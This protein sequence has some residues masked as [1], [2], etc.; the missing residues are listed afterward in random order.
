MSGV[1][2]MNYMYSNNAN[3]GQITLT[4]NFDVKTDPNTDQI[5]AQMRQGQAAS[6]LPSEVNSY[7]VTVQKSTAAPL[8]LFDL[9]SPNGT[10]DSEFL[11]N[12][13]YIN[14]N[15]QLT[16]VPGIASVSVFSAGQYAMRFWVKPDQLAKLQITVPEIIDAI[17]T[18]NN[19]NP[20]GQIGS[21]PVPP[22]QEY[23]YTVRSQGRL[24]TEEEFGQIVVRAKSDGSIVRLKDVAR[25][26]LG[27]Q[28]YNLQGRLDGKPAAVVAIYQLPGSNAIAAAKGAKALMVEAKKRFPPGLDYAVALDTTLPVTEGIVEIE[29]TLV[30]ALVLVILVVYLFLQGW[31]ATLIPLL[32]V[33]VSLIGTFAL[34]P[35]LGFSIN[36]LSLFGLVLAI[37]LVVDDAIVV[38]EAVEHH[39]EEGMSPREATL[40]AMEEV[41]GPVISIALILASVFIPVALVSGIQGRLNKQ[42]AVTIAVS[43]IISA[44]NAL[45]LSPALAAIMLRPRKEARGP[46]AGFFGAFNRGFAKATRGYISLSRG[47]IR[48]AVI[49]VLILA[50][51]ALVDGFFGK[52]LPTSFLP[53]EDYGFLFL[54][55]QLLPAASL[56]R[57]DHVSRK[58]ETILKQTDGVQF[59]TTINGFSLLNRVSASYNG[60]CFVSLQPWSERKQ[61]AQEILKSVNAKLA[62][63]V[64]EAMAFAF[65]PPAIPGLGNSGGFPLWLQDRSGG[66]VELLDQ[67]LQKFLAAA[68]QRP[69]L[70]GVGSQFSASS[71]QIYADVD[72]D[73]VLKQGVAVADVYQTM[74][75]YLGGL[76]LNQ[77]NR[78]GRQWRV[79]LQAE[80]EERLSPSDIEQY[81]VRNNDGN[82]VPLS[83]LVTTR[84]ISGPEYTNRFNVYRAAQ[85]IGSAA[86]GYSSGQAMAALEEV[87]KQTLPPEIGYDWSDLSYQERQASGTTTRVFGLSLV[88]VFLILAALYE[89]WSLPFSVLLTIPIAIFGAFLGLWLRGY[90]LDVY[91]QI[92]LIVLIGLAAKNAILIVEFAKAELEKGRDLID[93]ALEGARLRLRPILMTSFAFIFG[94]APL[95]IASGAG[96]ASR[97][98]LGTVVIVGMLAATSIAIFLIPL[99]FYLVEK[100]TMRF[101]RKHDHEIGSPT[102]EP[103]A[104]D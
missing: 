39:I 98:I 94:S 27:A 95:W 31:R 51:F 96:A 35:L 9:Y 36:T 16:R 5:L 47:L 83:S 53:E 78:F 7:G 75:A 49:A 2:N 21:E 46:L 29:H 56:E 23:T 19:V 33:P 59:Y 91:A 92:G 85:I 89:S 84:R 71:P 102:P 38:V 37:G 20:A 40:K 69:E 43:V 97:R 48:K 25:A 41:S 26:Q 58:V 28:V 11:A 99:T 12:Y 88:F 62:N 4:V 87:A 30:E 76:F 55:I 52:R 18:Q 86:P 45:T 104:G 100:F 82:M 77:F 67:N 3:N 22:G 73:K 32:A 50:G 64:P 74:Q 65:S 93:A 10:Y 6:Q 34:F 70:A 24:A 103:A 42:F 63:E 1:D 90:D 72:R 101:S 80:G 66:S 15:D 13:A 14:L 60:F 57:T 79:F 54:N 8:M 44:F 81:Y 68:R 61:T 17:Q